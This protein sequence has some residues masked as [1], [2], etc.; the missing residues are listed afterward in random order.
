LIAN[1]QKQQTVVRLKKAYSEISQALKMAEAEYGTM[2]SW[3]LLDFPTAFDRIQYFGENYLTK[4]IKT[5]EKCYPV[6]SKCW[7]QPLNIKQQSLGAYLT[8]NATAESAFIAS[9]GY[10]VYYWVSASGSNGWIYIDIDGPKKG[11]G[12]LGKDVFTF[13]FSNGIPPKRAGVFPKGVEVLDS[14][15][16]EQ[17]FAGI[18]N[19]TAYPTGG[20]SRTAGSIAGMECAAVIM[21]DGWEIAPDYPW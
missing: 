6:S 9:S 11:P 3:D 20:C 12:I 15:T 13:V 21:L 8:E 18:D 7:K 10:S 14:P 16:R 1:Y 5:V 2:D 19:G 4:Y 17:L